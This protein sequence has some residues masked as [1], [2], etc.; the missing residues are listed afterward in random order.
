MISTKRP[1]KKCLHACV[2]ILLRHQNSSH[3]E[4]HA[5]YCTF[6]LF[7]IVNVTSQSLR[8][9]SFPWYFPLSNLLCRIS[10]VLFHLIV[11]PYRKTAFWVVDRKSWFWRTLETTLISRQLMASTSISELTWSQPWFQSTVL[12]TLETT[13]I[14]KE[15]HELN[16]VIKVDFKTKQFL[17]TLKSRLISK[18]NL[19]ISDVNN[20]TPFSQC[21]TREIWRRYEY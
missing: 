6:V 10:V 17:C 18:G 11:Y 5:L 15:S 20:F 2:I 16:L 8:N 19:I 21:L 3:P 4:Q 14:L 12:T 9:A 13:L 1:S 7:S